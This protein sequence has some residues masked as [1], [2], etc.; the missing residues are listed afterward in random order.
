M[1]NMVPGQIVRIQV[2]FTPLAT[3]DY[4][5]GDAVGGLL[6][7]ANAGRTPGGAGEIVGLNIASTQSGVFATNLVQLWLFDRSFT[8]TIDNEQFD[9][10]V[11]EVDDLVSVISG[12]QTDPILAYLWN[13]ATTSVITYDL[14]PH[15]P[16]VL[17]AN[18]TSLF[19][20]IRTEQVANFAAGQTIFATLFVKYND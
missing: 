12:S 17:E 13:F 4:S 8:P 10:A 15:I 16:Y 14:R 3:P 6:T 19:G 5:P 9:M 2:S 18:T 7:F 20:Q 1:Q 11:T